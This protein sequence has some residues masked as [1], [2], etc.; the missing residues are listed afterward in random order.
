[1]ESFDEHSIWSV[2]TGN[3]LE[4]F[5]LSIIPTYWQDALQVVPHSPWGQPAI[6]LNEDE[7]SD[8]NFP[9]VDAAPIG[10]IRI[11]FS[12]SQ[13]GL[14]LSYFIPLQTAESQKGVVELLYLAPATYAE[15][16]KRV[17]RI[18]Q[19]GMPSWFVTA[20]YADAASLGKVLSPK[21]REEKDPSNFTTN[22]NV[23][24]PTVPSGSTDVTENVELFTGALYGIARQMFLAT[25][26]AQLEASFATPL[27]IRAEGSDWEQG[28]TVP[29]CVVRI[30]AEDAVLFDMYVTKITHIFSVGGRTATTQWNGVY[31]RPEDGVEGCAQN[32][33]YNPIYT[34]K[35]LS[36][37]PT[38]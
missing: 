13:M 32:G 35:L 31:C 6:T 37:M 27:L 10:G 3:V 8:I 25:C 38:V 19:I 9:G 33:D 17:G 11:A 15:A 21:A 20:M 7:I 36:N 28:Y 5:Q 4:E 23:T 2:L 24:D 14:D 1:V 34:A 30:E 29:G 12:P 26:R 18:I 16:T 22:E